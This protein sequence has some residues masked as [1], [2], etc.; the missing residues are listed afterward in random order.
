MSLWILSSSKRGALAVSPGFMSPD[1]PCPPDSMP[2][3]WYFQEK[4]RRVRWFSL[5]D[6]SPAM[7]IRWKD[8][9][10]TGWG[11]PVSM[12]SPPK[13]LIVY[14]GFVFFLFFF[15][16]PNYQN[17]CWILRETTGRSLTGWLSD[18]LGSEPTS[19]LLS[20]T[21]AV[22][23]HSS[24]SFLLC[25]REKDILAFLKV[26]DLLSCCLVAWSCP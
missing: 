6:V 11:W 1:T 8:L 3:S 23:I 19:S 5:G 21:E 20:W 18:T 9:P 2:H 24:H 16:R 7:Q 22:C 17:S 12:V 14:F 25:L 15:Y 4:G 10:Q 26:L 13:S